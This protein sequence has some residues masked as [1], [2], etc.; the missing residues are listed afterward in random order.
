MKI[1]PYTLKFTSAFLCILSLSFI[2]GN[3]HANIAESEPE[4]TTSS[5]TST[6]V[7]D[8][9]YIVNIYDSNLGQINTRIT[10]NGNDFQ[11]NS[12]TRAEGLASLVMGGDLKQKCSFET[13]ESNIK[14]LSSSVEKMRRNAFNKSIEIDWNSNKIL[15]EK[16]ISLDIPNGYL[17]DICNFHF[18][19]AYTDLEFL[20]NNTIY[21]LDA[22]KQQTKGYVF[23]S[24]SPETLETPAGVFHT[25]KIILERE[26]N[27]DRSFIFWITEENP[28]FPIKMM[29]S[30]KKNSRTMTLKSIQ[31]STNTEKEVQEKES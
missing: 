14:S 4:K 19:A 2:A 6:E 13:K 24:A 5:P 12:I 3:A 15:F 10:K 18:A 30:R 1:N 28:Y 17:V 16:D 9:S 8:L 26:L 7:I 31:Q 11:I 22:K 27:P 29:D 20:K 23:K 25:T 21:A